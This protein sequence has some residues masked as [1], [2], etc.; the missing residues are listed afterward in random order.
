ML[1]DLQPSSNYTV[2][3]RAVNIRGPSPYSDP[4]QFRTLSKPTAN[5]G[6][7]GPL[8]TVSGVPGEYTWTQTDNE[9][10]ITFELPKEVGAKRLSVNF[11]PRHLR[12]AVTGSTD[13]LL[14]ADTARAVKTGNCTWYKDPD[15]NEYH[16][17]LWK[18]DIGVHWSSVLQGHPRV[19]TA[20]IPGSEPPIPG[21]R[22]TAPNELEFD[23]METL[24]G[25]IK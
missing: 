25:Q 24:L 22:R 20:L 7:S 17:S 3:V 5:N 6:G 19:D 23:D 16:I 4:E 2:R 11:K 14:D 9:V 8:G 12:V 21:A 15:R 10:V 1:T 18:V 13:V